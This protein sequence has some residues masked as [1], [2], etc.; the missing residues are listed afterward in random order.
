MLQRAVG[1][2]RCAFPPNGGGMLYPAFID[3]DLRLV[4]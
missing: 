4:Q 1:G 3:V 2:M